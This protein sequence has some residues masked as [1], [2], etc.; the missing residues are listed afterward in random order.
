MALVGAELV[1]AYANVFVPAAAG[2]EATQA[3]LE[4]SFFDDAD[5]QGARARY[6]ETPPSASTDEW[7]TVQ[8]GGLARSSTK[9]LSIALVGIKAGSAAVLEAYFDNVMLKSQPP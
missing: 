3:G 6:F 1:I 8:A 7:V 9:P 4:V 2:N 5:C